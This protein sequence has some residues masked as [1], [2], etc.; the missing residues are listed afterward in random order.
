MSLRIKPD[1]SEQSYV[2]RFMDDPMSAIDFPDTKLRF[3]AGSK[4]WHEH[5]NPR[6][7]RC[8]ALDA[9]KIE[10]REEADTKTIV[11]HAAVF[12]TLSVDLWGFREKIAPGAF[13]DAVKEDDVRALFNHNPD[14]VLGRNKAGTLRLKEDEKGL[15]IEVDPPDT[16]VARDL[17]VSIGRGDITQMSFGFQ[18]VSDEWDYTDR[19]NPI[20]TLKKVKL[21]DVSPVTYPAYED[22]DVELNA[23]EGKYAVWQQRIAEI[24]WARRA[25]YKRR[26]AVL[27]ANRP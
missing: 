5:G 1:E 25:A 7:R 26:L 3:S 16:Q 8:F 11:G 27:E 14:Y 4:R 19:A 13:A 6:L 15:A 24:R 18:L 22:T 2:E 21:Y 12:N 20:R 10:A 9:L 17:M 23:L